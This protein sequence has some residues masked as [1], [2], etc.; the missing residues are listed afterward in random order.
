MIVKQ[1]LLILYWSVDM[2][3]AI[4]SDINPKIV[5]LCR[6][7]T[8]SGAIKEYLTRWYPSA[9]EICVKKISGHDWCDE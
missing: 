9:E 5:V 6:P 3:Y 1:Y 8:L 7:H 2:A 4:T